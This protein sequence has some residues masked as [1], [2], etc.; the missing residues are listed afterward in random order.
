MAV[1][2]YALIDPDT[3]EPF[4]VGK[5]NRPYSRFRAHLRDLA[6]TRKVRHLQTLLKAGKTP[7]IRVL[8][9]LHEGNVDEHEQR[10]IEWLRD[11]GYGLTN[12][13]DGGAGASFKAA[14]ADVRAEIKSKRTRAKKPRWGSLS[15]DKRDA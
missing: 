8:E 5:S 2:I 15:I 3:D 12:M 10:W 4:Y 6:D 11:N 1:Y 14:P 9:T 7:D 13:A